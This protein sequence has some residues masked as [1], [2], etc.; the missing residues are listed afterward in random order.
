MHQIGVGVLGPVFRTYE[1]ARDRLVA[2][3]VFQ[4]DITPEQSR[5]LGEALERLLAVDLSHPGLV[6]PIA[7]GFQDEVPYLAQEYVAAESLDVAMRHYAPAPF[8]TALPFIG[9]IAEAIDAAHAQGVV[10]GALHLRDVFVTPD[11]ARVTGFGVVKALEA[12]GLAGPI[13]RPYTAPEIIA[14]REWGGEA[15]VFAVAAIAYELVTG[16]RAA[17]TG[18]QMTGRLA[19]IEGVSDPD[20]LQE[21]FARAL[22]EDPEAR[23]SSAARFVAALEVAVGPDVATAG[24]T[25]EDGR[26]GR[27]TVDL[28]A[29]LERPPADDGLAA[30]GIDAFTTEADELEPEMDDEVDELD[31]PE[32]LDEADELDTVDAVDE[33]AELEDEEPEDEE[34]EDE[35]IDEEVEEEEEEELDEVDEVE[36]AEG[37]DDGPDDLVEDDEGDED[38]AYSES[39]VAEVEADEAELDDLEDEDADEAELDDLEDEDADEAGEVAELEDRE[40]LAEEED[41]EE[42]PAASVA[43]SGRRDDEAADGGDLLADSTDRGFPVSRVRGRGRCRR[44]RR[45]RRAGGGRGRR[46]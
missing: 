38:E 1:P 46:R 33:T 25:G 14:G 4:L 13:R 24:T 42:Q 32:D 11:E 23:Y 43:W 36:E 19:S 2:V 10:H 41:L 34:P 29:G 27:P 5:A 17:G 18:E 40:D 22:A 8:A 37:L 21:A 12:L 28:L 30:R 31:E 20:A 39:E 7:V 15:D 6:A 35:E 16:R 9:R 26:P 44:R 45:G 3:K